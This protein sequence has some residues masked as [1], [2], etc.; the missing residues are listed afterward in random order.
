[1]LTHTQLSDYLQPTDA[2]DSAHPAVVDFARDHTDSADGD[3]QKGIQLYYAV[4]DL[5]RYDPYQIH[6][7]VP[8][9]RASAT[10][11]AKRGWCISK[12]VLLAASCRAVGIPARL[13]FADV[14]NHLS[15]ERLRQRM[16]G[17]NLFYW[18]GYT[19]IF[20]ADRWVKATPAFNIELCEKFRLLPLEFDG[21]SDSIYHPFD[22]E[23]N[24]HM[25]Y[26]THRGVYS[27]LP[28]D[29]IILTFDREYRQIESQPGFVNADFDADVASETA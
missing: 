21:Q 6:L 13:G 22:A 20:L 17:V 2:I 12:A 26:V 14:R 18:H 16:G 25:E 10:L 29:E 1:L 27:D 9:L 24:R 4:R 11:E 19:E 5:I 28:L 3:V 8:A 7:T 15:T 23:G